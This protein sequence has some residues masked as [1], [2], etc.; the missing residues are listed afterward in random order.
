MCSSQKQMSVVACVLSMLVARTTA[1]NF[2]GLGFDVDDSKG[3][4]QT[5]ATATV[6]GAW[7]S[8]QFKLFALTA[9]GATDTTFSSTNA[10]VA[11]T[12]TVEFDEP[13]VDE[14]GVT[15]N[16]I[17]NT[18]TVKFEPFASGQVQLGAITYVYNDAQRGETDPSKRLY[19]KSGKV[20]LNAQYILGGKTY[21]AQQAVITLTATTADH[22]AFTSAFSLLASTVNSDVE[23]TI[24]ARDKYGNVATGYSTPSGKTEALKVNSTR[25]T[26]PKTFKL[27]S[28]AAKVVI[29]DTKAEV[30]QITLGG[31]S[32]KVSGR[33]SIEIGFS[34]GKTASFKFEDPATDSVTV[35]KAKVFYARTNQKIV[36]GLAAMD[37][38]GNVATAENEEVGL[39]FPTGVVISGPDKVTGKMSGFVAVKFTNGYSQF[40]V[41]SSK[42]QDTPL[43]LKK[44]L[45][46]H[47]ANF[48]STLGLR[49]VEVCDGTT[50]YQ[51]S[52][53]TVLCKSVR[54]L[55]SAGSKQTQAPNSTVN[56]ICIECNGSTEFQDQ[57][58]EAFCHPMGPECVKGFAE[59]T[60][61]SN[62]T[63]RTCFS[64]DGVTQYQDKDN[65]PACKNVTKCQT[66][67]EFE[68]RSTPTVDTVCR[69]CQPGFADA[70][71]N[72]MTTCTRCNPGGLS[73]AASVLQGATFTASVT[74]AEPFGAG[75]GV[76]L[77]I[78]YTS[79]ASSQGWL[80]ALS[81]ATTQ[82]VATKPAT[83]TRLTIPNNIAP[84]ASAAGAVSYSSNTS[85]SFEVLG[86]ESVWGRGL[87]Y[88]VAYV[89]NAGGSPAVTYEDGC[90]QI[91]SWNDQPTAA[92]AP[93]QTVCKNVTTCAA[94]FG[95]TVSYTRSQDRKCSACTGTT[96]FQPDAGERFCDPVT[97]C[98]NGLREQVAPNTTTDRVCEDV[99]CPGLA[100][101]D[102]GYISLPCNTT[103]ELEGYSEVCEYTCDAAQFF[104]IEFDPSW[105]NSRRTCQQD[106]KFDGVAPT[107][108]C[109]NGLILDP[110]NKACVSKCP[111]GLFQ[112]KNSKSCSA[113]K[114]NC[115]EGSYESTACEAYSDR[116]C[117]VCDTCGKG[118]WS[119]AG[120]DRFSNN[121]TIC[122][123]HSECPEGEWEAA[124]GTPTTDRKC[125]K[126]FACPSSDFASTGC[127]G[128]QDTVCSRMTTCSSVEFASIPPPAIQ[129]GFA[130]DVVCQTRQKCGTGQFYESFGDANNDTKCTTCTT[131]SGGTFAT[132]V[133]V[134]G[135]PGSLGQD[136]QCSAWQTC[137]SGQYLGEPGSSQHDGSCAT[138]STCQP[139][140]YDAGGCFNT[141]DTTCKIRKVC[142]PVT[143]YVNTTGVTGSKHDTQCA[144]C[145]DCEAQNLVTITA[146][147]AEADAS[148]Q[149]V[150]LTNNQTLHCARGKVA[151]GVYPNHFCVP[152]NPCKDGSYAK[153]GLSCLDPGFTFN[154]PTTCTPWSAC[155]ASSFESAAPTSTS[156][157]VCKS[158][159]KCPVGSYRTGGCTGSNNTMC[160]KETPCMANNTFEVVAGTQ[161][162][163]HKCQTCRTCAFSKYT[164]FTDF[165]NT[166]EYV[167]EKCTE[168]TD[169]VCAK[170]SS[171]PS[172]SIVYGRGTPS[173][174]RQCAKC[175][176]ILHGRA[177]GSSTIPKEF[178]CPNTIESICEA[179]PTPAP[180]PAVY[181][182]LDV[183]MGLS[184]D[185]QNG[186][187]F[188]K[189][190]VER[191]EEVLATCITNFLGDNTTL[192]GLSIKALD[193]AGVSVKY[194]VV[195]GNAIDMSDALLEATFASLVCPYED[196]S[197][198]YTKGSVEV[199]LFTTSTTT[200]T[201]T[202]TTTTIKATPA[203]TAAPTLPAAP[204]STAAP[205][206]AEVAPTNAT[207]N[208]TAP[209]ATTV[210]QTA[211]A[212]A[213]ADD[214]LGGGA[215][216]GI[217]IA[218]LFCL[219]AVI[220]GAIL[221]NRSK[222]D[223]DSG[224]SFERS[225]SI[226]SITAPSESGYLGVSATEEGSVFSN[227]VAE[228]NRKLRSEVAVMQEKIALKDASSHHQQVSQKAAQSKFEKAIAA[229]I[230]TENKALADEIKAMQSEVK[231]MKNQTAYQKAAADQVKLLAV[232][233]QLEEEIT[234]VNEIEQVALAAISEFDAS[235]ESGAQQYE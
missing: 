202:I 91:D 194:N 6:G 184:G 177:F 235:L 224:R 81:L 27:A 16:Q 48:D 213:S 73:V 25:A 107:C 100:A 20:T 26:A 87:Y 102:Y 200:L 41:R 185:A 10:H 164:M 77:L 227:Q 192:D 90:V 157:R 187:A 156:D 51:D 69:D 148:C 115:A 209:A 214:G 86:D 98:E 228:E 74:F 14:K 163:P 166:G 219:I 211:A 118:T 45:A 121:N 181:R 35:D 221:Y 101:P 150:L 8:R 68:S 190:R 152:C 52:P 114:D 111:V 56:R 199:S 180:P 159:A 134:K 155:G 24:N 19:E 145:T 109:K 147:S 5:K 116:Q 207:V 78:A 136:T 80:T 75:K 59:L 70:D 65:Q 222:Q 220:I 94:G 47:N 83:V 208:A 191:L 141:T 9:A 79:A 49:F 17:T 46:N 165:F 104:Q 85:A 183:T 149:T 205:V 170:F 135:S 67:Q 18:K 142:N 61:P 127:C 193:A 186:I 123:P 161:T 119:A 203:P 28:G 217:V 122:Q 226:S 233:T 158:C 128:A 40:Y 140:E 54:N 196:V 174:D 125:Q 112:G 225:G 139:S 231:K 44:V 230:S 210:E 103:D 182:Y 89:T 151:I 43:S 34:A 168:L 234:R 167:K 176:G 4:R 64:C 21:P 38:F 178:M 129:G 160:K 63:N 32:L 197:L 175:D 162:A 62:S 1:Q 173:A 138:C 105:K 39:Q 218:V 72:P 198:V 172:D 216:A 22:V 92:S 37:A 206:I 144:K 23:L 58:N 223:A 84:S 232:K 133:C 201:T 169:T 229:R 189:M 82:C 53:G 110:V 31:G 55:C 120:C 131:C 11:V 29:K 204:T 212:A 57:P 93:K 188:G 12:A 33:A 88:T 15:V 2:A 179:G 117:T 95:Q 3:G 30:V 50:T 126:C 106:G 171:C 108:Q 13:Q 60:H 99:T 130:S 66:G 124:P 113:C 36:V 132:A 154:K 97:L 96:D 215:I 146:C 153:G 42:A 71:S 7:Q 195:T 143:E 137:A 76:E